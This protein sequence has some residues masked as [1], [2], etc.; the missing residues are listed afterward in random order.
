MVGAFIAR[1]RG[2]TDPLVPLALLRSRT[3][4]VA[5]VV[6]FLTTGALFAVNVFV[7]LFLQ[8]TTGAS[9]TV[10]GLLLVPMMVGITA[11]TTV[12]GRVLA[13]TGRY[14]RIPTL[15]LALMTGAL[16]ALAVVSASPSRLS[17]C[18]A[19]AVFGLG[20][21][22]VG[23]VLTVAVQNDVERRQLGIAMATTSFFRGLGGAIG[24][25]A[26]GTVFAAR[27]ALTTGGI[28]S[29][30]Q[31]SGTDR[32]ELID[33]VQAVFRVSVAVAAVALLVSLLLPAKPLDAAPPSIPD[34][35]AEPVR[36][37]VRTSR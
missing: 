8:T 5:A 31:L 25:A 7:P 14:R 24:A 2:A 1:E 34:V 29:I 32:A 10:A 9:P 36:A 19:L 13:A 15:G 30:S 12:A 3:I 6:L 21:G 37:T 4:A 20:F 26:L 27:T 35:P 33:G 11:S 17:T 22:V 18:L 16:A 23:Q 28:G